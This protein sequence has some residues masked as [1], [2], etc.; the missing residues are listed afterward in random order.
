MTNSGK[1]QK[2]W[3][4]FLVV[5][6]NFMWATQVPVIRLIGNRLGPVTLA[7]IPMILS[8]AMFLPVFW[9]EQRR[10]G[11]GL[12]WQWKDAKHFL[13]AGFFGV[14]LMQFLYTL[15][16]RWTLAANAGVITLTIPVT[17]AIFASFFLKERLN[18]VRILSFILALLG[19]LL[20]SLT[21][22]RSADFRHSQYLAGNLVF[23]LACFCCGF[24]NTYCKFLVER[25]Y[26]ELEIL[27]YTTVIGSL[28]SIPLLLWVEPFHLSEFLQK[29]PVAIGGILELSF[30]V[31][32]VSML[33]FFY[34][35]KRM[36]VTQAILGN[37]LLPLFIAMLGILLLGERI[38]VLTLTGGAI[39]VVSTLMV[40]V[41]EAD[42]LRWLDLGKARR[43]SWRA[44]E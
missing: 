18:I 14:F 7:Y 21:D 15:G 22:L 19:V 5:V 30:I 31:Y 16:S 35:L 32:G 6:I 9:H 39:I 24:F 37:Y 28:S 40:T 17:V 42:L 10:R 2:Y 43:A 29:G 4:W 11:T 27:V 41:Y 12:R 23:L 44:E 33:L 38:T 20:T 34:V 1:V 36:D 13:L 26:T 25:K 8:T 3:D